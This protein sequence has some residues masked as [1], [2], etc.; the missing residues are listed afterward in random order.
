MGENEFLTPSSQQQRSAGVRKANV[1]IK[2]RK[3][4]KGREEKRTENSHII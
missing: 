4:R 1:S 2:L 3:V